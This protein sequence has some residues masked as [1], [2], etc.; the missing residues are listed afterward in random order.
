MNTDIFYSVTHSLW[1]S[2]GPTPTGIIGD[3]WMI[4]CLYWLVS[5]LNRKKTKRRETRSVG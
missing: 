1:R 4:F 2:F 3:L 5:A